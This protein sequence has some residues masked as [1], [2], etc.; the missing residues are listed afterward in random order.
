MN[1]LK[2]CPN[3]DKCILDVKDGKV[4][5]QTHDTFL[6]IANDWENLDW[7]NQIPMRHILYVAYSNGKEGE[8]LIDQEQ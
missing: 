3:K 1:Q 2:M 6:K 4:H 7:K 8:I 5:C